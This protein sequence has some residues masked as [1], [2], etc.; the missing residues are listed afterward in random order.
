M[1][2]TGSN[3]VAGAS[4]TF[5]AIAATTTF[6]SATSL[7][8]IVP[9]HALGTAS[10]TVTQGGLTST[11]SN[12]FTYLPSAT[13]TYATQPDDGTFGTLHPTPGTFMPV[14]S[15]DTA[16]PGQTYSVKQ[17]AAAN[18]ANNHSVGF[19]FQ[20]SNAPPANLGNPAAAD[21]NGLYARWYTYFPQATVN[22]MNTAQTTGQGQIKVHLARS[23]NGV[24]QPWFETG[25]GPEFN[26]GFG[27]GVQTESDFD[28]GVFYQH[29]TGY[30]IPAGQWVEW[31]VS[32]RRDTAA[33]IGYAKLW[34][35]GK[36]VGQ[37]QHANYGSDN[38]TDQASISCGMVYVQH[39][40]NPLVVY[41]AGI[42]LANGYIEPRF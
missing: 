18:D 40:A 35:N 22:A 13:V 16:L 2:L 31:Q 30:T 14:I 26:T 19:V 29:N 5:D 21:P 37:S 15:T 1:F 4:V 25:I 12:S 17:A 3:F 32:Y 9:A 24:G 33:H 8:V 10:V 6:V 39:V 11:L 27:T 20:P 41:V 23:Y 28:T 7:Q 34:I 38:L 36:L 42:Q